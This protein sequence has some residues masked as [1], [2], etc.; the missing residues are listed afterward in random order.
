MFRKFSALL[1]S[2][3]MAS[4][5]FLPVLAVNF[6]DVS[7]EYWAYGPIQS[8]AQQNIITGYADN[9]FR[10]DNPV[11]RAEFAT[12]IIKAINRENTPV[13]STFNFRD[14]P[15]SFWAYNNIQRAHNLGLISGFPGNLFKP[16][17]NILKVEVIAILAKAIQTGLLSDAEVREILNKYYD[18]S[19]ISEWAVIPVAKASKA[20]L[21]VNYPQ[22]N[23]LMP[24]KKA[25]RAE[26][27]AML[28]NLRLTL[29]LTQPCVTPQQTLGTAP[30]TADQISQAA[31][32][33]ATA[34]VL[35]RGEIA[36]IQQNSIIPTRK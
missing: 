10:P 20:N 27:A 22:P 36:T 25:T 19:S 35:L 34:N 33:G 14:V 6:Y 31:A 29:G 9:T 30:T 15:S 17:A 3:C 21:I 7:S 26:V 28:N 23:F 5:Y 13:T 12:M 16:N 8:L 1:I 24:Q 18:A 2:F 32:G 11:S 4:M